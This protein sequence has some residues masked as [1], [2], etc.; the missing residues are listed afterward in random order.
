MKTIMKIE[1]IKNRSGKAKTKVAAYCRV[2]TKQ[3]EQRTSY[4]T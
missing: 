2:S 1:P 4:D 3:D